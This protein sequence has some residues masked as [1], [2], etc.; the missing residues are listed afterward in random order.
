VRGDIFAIRAEIARS[1][2]RPVR[3][4]LPGNRA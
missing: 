2:C 1:R 4:A 3:I